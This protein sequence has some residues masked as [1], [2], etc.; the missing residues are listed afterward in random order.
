MELEEEII[1]IEDNEEQEF[2]LIEDDIQFILP[3]TQ[4]K[5][6]TPTKE[7][8]EVTPDENYTGLSKVTVNEI[9]EE[10][11][12]PKGE[13]QI[14]ENGIVDIKEY[15]NANVK[16]KAKSIREKDIN[17]FDY[18]GTLIDTWSLDELQNKTELPELP[19]H[20]GLI[21]EGWNWALEELKEVNLPVDVGTMYITDDGATRLYIEIESEIEKKVSLYL[22]QTIAN[23]VE[24]NWGDG[25]E[26]ETFSSTSNTT[27]SH[28]YNSIG[29]YV[30]SIKVNEGYFY[31]GRTSNSVIGSTSNAN[32]YQR[33]ILKKAEIGEKLYQNRL[34]SYC[35]SNCYYL[36]SVTLPSYIR[37]LDGNNFE[38]CYSLKTAIIPKNSIGCEVSTYVYRNCASLKNICVPKKNR[39]SST[40]SFS[41][42]SNLEKIFI[43][44]TNIGANLFSNNYNLKN[45]YI[46]NTMTDLAGSAFSTN[47]SLKKITIPE[48]ITSIGSN[49]FT[50]C[51][52]LIEVHLKATTPPTLSNISAFSSLPTQAKFYVPYSEDGSVIEAYRTATNW[53]TFADRFVEEIVE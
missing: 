25:S 28:E 53:S 27:L 13:I 17:F 48:N 12:V 6:I 7:I 49:C 34:T 3:V 52:S 8:Q 40:N 30:I 31:L 2:I 26:I 41:G 16:V 32:A 4:E 19:T 1:L 43:S 5:T 36:K 51:Y 33:N 47:S 35:F 50:A 22:R 15:E 24:I 20:E 39:G 14:T 21:S 11:I 18:D 42:C 46:Y 10:Y 29:N 44:F 23:A 9:P 37:A 38:Y 45:I